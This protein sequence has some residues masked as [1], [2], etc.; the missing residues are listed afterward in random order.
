MKRKTL[1]VLCGAVLTA[2]WMVSTASV[3]QANPCSQLTAVADSGVLGGD[4]TALISATCTGGAGVGGDGGNGGGGG[5]GFGGS[6]G[7]GGFLAPG[8][9][10]GPGFGG[11]G[12]PGGAGGDGYGGWVVGDGN[13]IFW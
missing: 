1:G 6:G 10:G 13:L 4:A 9:P 2:G 5:A 8:G 3:A 11:F 7:A 12:G